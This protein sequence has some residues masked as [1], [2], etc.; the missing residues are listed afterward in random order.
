MCDNK[1][2]G[3]HGVHTHEKGTNKVNIKAGDK[4]YYWKHPEDIDD[5]T[6]HQH[7]VCVVDLNKWAFS[8][9]RPSQTGQVCDP[10]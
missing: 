8:C 6:S 3:L 10:V 9:P 5:V 7:A 2:V 1:Y 4:N